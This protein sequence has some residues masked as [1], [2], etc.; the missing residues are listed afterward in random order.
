MELMDELDVEQQ[1]AIEEGLNEDEFTLFDLLKKDDL[2]KADRDCGKQANRN[3][4]ASI[5]A[6]LSEFDRFWEKGEIKAD[7][8]L[9]ILDEVYTSLP[10]PPFTAEEKK[11]VHGCAKVRHSRGASWSSFSPA[12]TR[13]APPYHLLD[14]LSLWD[15]E[16]NLRKSFTKRRKS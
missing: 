2:A 13:S 6:R 8:E 14:Y 15:L 5:K 10:M 7:V 11:A 3:L 4:L 16:P 1:R 9:F 12:L